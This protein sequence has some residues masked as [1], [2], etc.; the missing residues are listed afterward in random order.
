MNEEAYFAIIPAIVMYDERLSMM[1]RLLYG[2]I[3]LLTKKDGYCYASNG[4]LANLYKC[5]ESTITRHIGQLKKYGYLTVEIKDNYQR[6]IYVNLPKEGDMQNCIGGY[7][8]LHRGVCKNDE[9]VIQNCID[10]NISQY[11]ES[12]K[13][14]KNINNSKELFD[15]QELVEPEKPK[16][17]YSEIME[18]WNR[19]PITNIKAIKGTRLTMLKA[20]LKDYTIDEILSAISNI[21]ESPFLLGQNNKGW[22]I[23]F[24]WFIRP[25]NFIKVYEGNY[26]G[27]RQTKNRT[28]WNDA[29]A[30]YEGAMQDLEGLIDE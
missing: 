6:K 16:K 30:G 12:N 21:R 2:T 10:N 29:Q 27:Q 23:T 19:L 18:A 15:Q 11:Y 3:T 1:E 9:G 7:A 4:Y 5:N 20:R 14:N 26:T 8:K 13:N 24:D 25:N 22:Q 17:E 28:S